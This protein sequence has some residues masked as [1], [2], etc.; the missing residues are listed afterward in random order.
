MHIQINTADELTEQDR[1]ILLALAGVTE[2]PSGV[3]LAEEAKPETPK[4]RAPRKS[5]AEPKEEV[6]AP[7][8]KVETARAYT[9]EEEQAALDEAHRQAAEEPKET[10]T[11]DEVANVAT[12]FIRNGKRDEIAKILNEDL[13]VEKVTALKDSPEKV[14]ELLDLLVNFYNELKSDETRKAVRQ[15]INADIAPLFLARTEA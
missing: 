8:E 7:E 9:E 12:A 5:K 2:T 15:Q 1:A 10:P 3:L 14:P 13:G 11:L 4:K 6:A